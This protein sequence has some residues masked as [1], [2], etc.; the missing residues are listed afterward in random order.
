MM[1]AKMFSEVR[2]TIVGHELY[3]KQNLFSEE[4][5]KVASRSISTGGQSKSKDKVCLLIFSFLCDGLMISFVSV[6]ADN[7]PTSKTGFDAAWL[8]VSFT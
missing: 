7:D 6:K 3:T 2:F 8:A 1:V 5:E 4:Q